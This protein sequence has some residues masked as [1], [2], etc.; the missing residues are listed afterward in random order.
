M[1]ALNV[2]VDVE[3]EDVVMNKKLFL[4]AILFSVSR[5]GFADQISLPTTGEQDFR[6]G[7]EIPS[8]ATK[9]GQSEAKVL[10]EGRSSVRSDSQGRSGS[11]QSSS[12]R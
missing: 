1:P 6:N 5:V 10:P 8:F 2:D 9:C 7:A 3:V 4:A 12:A 11:A